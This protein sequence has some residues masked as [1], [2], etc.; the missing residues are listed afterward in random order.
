MVNSVFGSFTLHAKFLVFLQSW[1]CALDF[2]EEGKSS[3]LGDEAAGPVLGR[4]ES[5]DKSKLFWSVTTSCIYVKISE[6]AN[7]RDRT[8]WMCDIVVVNLILRL[9]QRWLCWALLA[10]SAG[11]KGIWAGK[12][13]YISMQ[14][15]LC[16]NNCSTCHHCTRLRKHSSTEQHWTNDTA[17]MNANHH[18]LNM[19]VCLAHRSICS[20]RSRWNRNLHHFRWPCAASWHWTLASN[21]ELHWT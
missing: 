9:E 7:I 13:R 21:G 5:D 18:C 20:G 16:Q 8:F 17:E 12:I 14:V 3:L 2:V 15:Q 19:I 10:W 1:V 6:I 11:L 4:M